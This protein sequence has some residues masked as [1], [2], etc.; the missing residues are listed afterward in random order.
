MSPTVTCDHCGDEDVVAEEPE[1][2]PYL[3]SLR[4]KKQWMDSG[5]DIDDEDD[6]DEEDDEESPVAYKRHAITR[7][8]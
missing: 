4:C 8:D 2:R 7:D 1:K 6:E 5:Q 3:C